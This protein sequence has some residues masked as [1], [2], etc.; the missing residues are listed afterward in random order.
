MVGDL[1]SERFSWF[2][3]WAR[4]VLDFHLIL[5]S[6]WA[7]QN[8]DLATIVDSIVEALVAIEHHLRTSL[9]LVRIRKQFTF[10]REALLWNW[11]L[12]LPS[13]L[14]SESLARSRFLKI[15]KISLVHQQVSQDTKLHAIFDFYLFSICYINWR[16]FMYMTCLIQRFCTLLICWR[17][18]LWERDIH[19]TGAFP[20]TA[21]PVGWPTK[22]VH[23][24]VS[25]GTKTIASPW[26]HPSW[27][28]EFCWFSDS[29][30]EI[31]YW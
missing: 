14:R 11:R 5:H 30:V 24:T 27:S 8:D 6:R 15:F 12:Q 20:T 19:K 31:L 25:G 28:L 4:P 16:Q 7:F 10:A 1:K 17:E 26:H 21:T 22:T 2:R 23:S 9:A 18:K 29:F 3:V 13:F